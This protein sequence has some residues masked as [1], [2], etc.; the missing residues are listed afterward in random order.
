M[1]GY[2]ERLGRTVTLDLCDVV[3]DYFGA[4]PA[5]WF[6]MLIGLGVIAAIVGAL[7]ACQTPAVK[8]RGRSAAARLRQ[9]A[10]A[11][12]P[13]IPGMRTVTCSSASSRGS[14]A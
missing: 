12:P 9:D 1:N 4:R 11:S 6:A 13:E 3:A 5:R 7:S 10:A 2:L 14:V 8:D